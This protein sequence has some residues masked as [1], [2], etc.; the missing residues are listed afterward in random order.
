MAQHEPG[1][2]ARELAGQLGAATPGKEIDDRQVV[3]AAPRRHERLR[4]VL[5]DLHEV[6]LLAQNQGQGLRVAGI[7]LYEKDRSSGSHGVRGV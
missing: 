6:P 1:H 4:P 5:R 3:A 2:A 7:V